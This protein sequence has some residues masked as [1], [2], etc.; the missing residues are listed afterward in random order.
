MTGLCGVTVVIKDSSEEKATAAETAA[1]N[2]GMLCLGVSAPQCEEVHKFTHTTD[3]KKEMGTTMD[4]KESVFAV[5]VFIVPL[6]VNSA[7]RS[8]TSARR[9]DTSH[10]ST[11]R[12]LKLMLPPSLR[13]RLRLRHMQLH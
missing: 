6:T 1:L 2:A 5:G 13:T 11:Q 3:T 9:E 8:A 4:V 10:G 7:W 12:E